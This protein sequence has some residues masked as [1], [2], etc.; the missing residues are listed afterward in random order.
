ML[1]VTNYCYGARH[2]VKHWRNVFLV[3]VQG[4]VDRDTSVFESIWCYIFFRNTATVFGP[5]YTQI[6]VKK[7]LEITLLHDF[8]V[9]FIFL[10][11]LSMSESLRISVQVANLNNWHDMSLI[12][13]WSCWLKQIYLL[14]IQNDAG[15]KVS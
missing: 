3:G 13:E 8:Y 10:P 14:R 5:N 6:A 12:I 2:P 7:Y 1:L 9:L 15:L 4:H 11:Y